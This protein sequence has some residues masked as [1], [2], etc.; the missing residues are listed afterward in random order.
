MDGGLS[1]R[2][3]FLVVALA[4]SASWSCGGCRPIRL[5][6]GVIHL[7]HSR[8]G[9]DAEVCEEPTV[10]SLAYDLDKLEA[11]IER[12]GSIVA[13]QPD[14]WGQARLTAHRQEFEAQMASQLNAFDYT[15]QGSV[16]ASDQAYFADALALS[17]AAAPRGARGG[18][19]STPTVSNS[20]TTTAA[21]ATSSTTTSSSSQ[22]SSSSQNL[23]LPPL[24]AAFGAFD[25]V[26]RTQVPT[27]PNLSFVGA[28]SGITV[29]PT[30]LLDER[31]RFVNHLQELR[32]INEGDDTADSPGY[33]LNLVR[34]PI[35]VLPGKFTRVS[36]GA[37]VTITMTPY[38][39]DDLLPVT[40]RNLVMNDLVDQLG[41]PIT[42]FINNRE[43]APY[44]DENAARDVDELL[45]LLQDFDDN[46]ACNTFDTDLGKLRLKPG[47]QALLARPEWQWVGGAIG[48]AAADDCPQVCEPLPEIRTTGHPADTDDSG[49]AAGP[50]NATVPS[51]VSPMTPLQRH[52]AMHV[53]MHRAHMTFRAQIPVP[54]TKSRRSRMPFPPTEIFDVYGYDFERMTVDAYR[55]LAKEKF[56]H[57][58]TAAGPVFYH[59]PDVQGYL[60]EELAA[61]YKFLELR[62]NEDLWTTF[63]QQSLVD[64]VRG[65]NWDYLSEQRLTFKKCLTA[66]V[67]E[68][69]ENP[70]C[71]PLSDTMSSLAWAIIVE[72]AL[73][74]DQLEQDMREAAAAKGCCQC[75]ANNEW[76]PY[77]LPEPPPEARESFNQYVRCRWP[78]H[79]FALDPAT[80][81]QNIV[82][83][84]SSRREM[85]LAMSMAFVSGRLSAN[86]MMRY[87][88]RIEY[89]FATVDLNGTDIG[90]SHGDETFGW[91]FYPRFQTPDVESNA[92]VFFRDLMIGGP[93]RDALLHMRRLEPGIRECYAIVIM[94]SFVPYATFNVSAN[95]FKLKSPKCK[96]LDT[97]DAM[98]LSRLVKN[99]QTC[100]GRVDDAAC[101]R[102][103][104]FQRLLVKAKQLESRLPFQETMVQIPYENTLGGFAMFNTGVTDLAPELTGFY[105]S[106]AIDPS[107]D[108]TLFL[109]GNHF[110]V[111]QTNVIAGGQTLSTPTM[112]SRQVIQVT[113]PK[114]AI[115]VGDKQ[116]Q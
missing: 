52:A 63:C 100:A 60:Q 8:F 84:F 41:F 48:C 105:G 115:Q 6:S 24:P 33:A 61:A 20:S 38:L 64:A 53:P 5:V 79:A 39:S 88:R 81:E 43:N 109:V 49:P 111:H 80:Q 101:Y 103:G 1:G 7:N 59:L 22:Q 71:R 27:P 77:F 35:S 96:E 17:A 83:T 89:D 19:T 26:S 114:N 98:R 99:V 40:F 45:E 50:K 75:A 10:E 55:V 110:S 102:D 107:N 108:T 94:P 21:P 56:S 69:A 32:R 51:N 92:T 93:N 47:L 104:D 29:E 67:F 112:L 58:S 113:I 78:I 82:D 65:R 95:W 46:D 90:F 97:T 14:V 73:L 44:F 85:Q 2:K 16:A 13:K 23:P 34:I 4:L 62:G 31:A 72:A 116:Q 74:N 66:K 86:N 36:Y 42:E 9:T 76:L 70:P 37:E 87:A 30:V 57:P 11:H 3:L 91:R 25:S 54:G 15:L 12:Y 18:S 68:R 28:S 106:E